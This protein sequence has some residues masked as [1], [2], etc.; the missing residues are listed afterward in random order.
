[1]LQKRFI[2]AWRRAAEAKSPAALDALLADKAE[3]ISPI[4]FE[5]IRERAKILAIFNAILT[6]LPDLAYTRCEK[7]ETGAIML[8]EGTVAGTLLKVEGI[9]VFTLGLDGKAFEL[10][11]FVRPLK[12]AVAFAEA[13]AKKLG[14][15]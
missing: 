11:V 5:P 7:T 10:K 6:V 9:D 4:A 12:A 2:D 13:M 15:A 3:L 1:M 14:T 8:F